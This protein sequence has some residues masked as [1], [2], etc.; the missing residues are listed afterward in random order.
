VDGPLEAEQSATMT[1]SLGETDEVW[2][3]DEDLTA[4]RL[5]FAEGLPG[6][7]L[8]VAYGV[9]RLDDGELVFGHVNR[10]GGHHLLPAV[11]LAS[12]CR[13]PSGTATYVLSP[14]QMADAVARLAPAEAATHWDHPNL[15]SWRT[16]IEGGSSDSKFVVIFVQSLDDPA[17]DEHDVRFREFVL[18]E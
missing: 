11:V 7:E 4:A 14:D 18:A 8:P 13:H 12:V 5:R 10:P 15:W 16:L 3:T 6:Y 2:T 17:V 9:G 1:R